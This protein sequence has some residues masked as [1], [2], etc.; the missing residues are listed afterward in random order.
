MSFAAF[1]PSNACGSVATDSTQALLLGGG[2][3]LSIAK[4]I[5]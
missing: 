3:A 1:H 5:S 4:L 2:C